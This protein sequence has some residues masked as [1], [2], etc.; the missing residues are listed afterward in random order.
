MRLVFFLANVHF[1]NAVTRPPVSIVQF[2]SCY[3]SRNQNSDRSLILVPSQLQLWT[4]GAWSDF[5]YRNAGNAYIYMLYL[6]M[7]IYLSIHI[8]V[9][10]GLC[11]DK[12]QSPKLVVATCRK[13]VEAQLELSLH[14]NIVRFMGASYAFAKEGSD[15][16]EAPGRRGRKGD[17]LQEVCHVINPS[18]WLP[19]L[20]LLTTIISSVIFT[21]FC[22][23]YFTSQSSNRL[24]CFEDLFGALV[25]SMAPDIGSSHHHHL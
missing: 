15:D 9:Q 11:C 1:D 6:S 10:T 24:L 5:L 21:H 17:F 19:T 16:E 8:P 22:S 14:P 12:W 3:D 13:E 2:A 7:H 25:N 23:V 18:S 4:I 20:P